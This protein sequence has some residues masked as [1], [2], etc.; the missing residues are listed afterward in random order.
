[1]FTGLIEQVGTLEK[2]SRIGHAGQIEIASRSWAEPFAI[3]ES[4][5]VEGVCLTLT[6]HEK[7]RL[8]FDILEETFYK[9]TLGSIPVGTQVNLERALSATGRLG[10]HIVNGHVDGIGK[11]TSFQQEGRDWILVATCSGAILEGVVYKG[12]MAVNGVSLTVT[13][14]TP[15]SFSMH[16]IPETMKRTSLHQLGAGSLVNLETDIIGKYIRRG[17]EVG[18]VMPSLTWEHLRT[19]GLESMPS[20][21]PIDSPDTM[22]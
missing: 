21:K 5:A 6:R 8:K 22:H 1:M 14:L 12:C 20:N 11:V 16:L 2:R 4:I 7:S 3:G 18:H 10:G 15:G 9:T 17:L 19:H 13:D